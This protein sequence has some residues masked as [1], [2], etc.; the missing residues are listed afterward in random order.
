M[1]VQRK[2]E[3]KAIMTFTPAYD[4]GKNILLGYIG[5]LTTQGAMLV[6]EKQVEINRKF[7]LAI[8]FRETPEIP[9][10]RLTIPARVAWCKQEKTSEFYN[11]GVEFLG[12]TDQNKKVIESIKKRYQFNKNPPT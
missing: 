7:I 2:E 9:A 11:T 8:Q 10:T 4:E 1:S 3:R 5:D 6:G 12:L